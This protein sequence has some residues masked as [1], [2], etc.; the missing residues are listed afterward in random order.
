MDRGDMMLSL[1]H[2]VEAH[3][4]MI[5]DL[6]VSKCLMAITEEICNRLRGG[7]KMYICGNGGSA[8]DAQH[9]AAEF[10]VRF[11]A[12]NDR[13]PLPVIAL[14]TDSSLITA[15][16]NDLSYDVVFERQVMALADS[17]DVVVGISTSGNSINILRALNAAKSQ[18]CV[19]IG[20]T[21]QQG[22][23]MNSMGLSYLFR[24]PASETARIQELHLLAWHCICEL[25]EEEMIRE[26]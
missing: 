23:Q 1:H 9:V 22:G 4:R 18:G 8:A 24:A 16:A 15:C 2:S 7:F 10:M 17:G 26:I 11:A 5:D 3:K 12:D 25:V 19:T 20:F 6:E 13:K 21:G 14:T